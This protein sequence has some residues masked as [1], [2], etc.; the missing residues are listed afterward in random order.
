MSLLV[1]DA[2]LVV[3]FHIRA[4]LPDELRAP[5]A[6]D[7][8]DLHAVGLIHPELARKTL[9]AELLHDLALKLGPLALAFPATRQPRC[10][11]LASA[12]DVA[13]R[14]EGASVQDLRAAERV[15][16]V[17]RLQVLRG[18]EGGQRAEVPLD[19][20]E[21]VPVAPAVVGWRAIAAVYRAQPP[22]QLRVAGAPG[23]GDA[24][25][26]ALQPGCVLVEPEAELLQ[27]AAQLAA[28][29]PQYSTALF[30]L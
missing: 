5:C 9:L 7:Q 4:R 1:V 29:L 24:A 27:D 21:C 23:R 19:L 16:N 13:A 6:D 11:E 10:A 25:L 2:V 15:P 12:A 18:A 28:Q 22:Q 20:E 3:Q 30:E 26:H 14:L 8:L 17:R